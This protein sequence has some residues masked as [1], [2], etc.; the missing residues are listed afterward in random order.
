[1]AVIEKVVGDLDASVLHP[2]DASRLVTMFSKGQRLCTAGVTVCCRQ[3]DK[4]GVWKRSGER[5]AADWLSKT[6]GESYKT[7]CD[8]LETAKAVDQLSHTR[9]ALVSGK[10][11]G[12]QAKEIAS[13]ASSAPSFE[14]ELLNAAQSQGLS[15]LRQRCRQIKA[16]SSGDEKARHLAIHKARRLRWWTD[17]LGAFRLDGSFTPEAGATLLAALQPMRDAVFAQARRQGRKEGFDAYGADALVEMARHT[18]S[19]EHTPSFRGPRALIK[20]RVDAK[21]LQR[22]HAKAGETCEIAGVG[23]V[24]VATAQK[25]AADAFVAALQCDGADIAS[26]CH[27]GRSIPARLRTAL[28]ERDPECVVPRCHAKGYLEIDHIV[29][30][31]QNGP[32]CLSNLARLCSFH[33]DQKTY[34]GYRLVGKPA[35]WRWLHPDDPDP[36]ESGPPGGDPPEGDPP[37]T[38]KPT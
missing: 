18:A 3:V 33:H 9:Q 38:A 1:M 20:V 27:M 25:L 13:A 12:A 10:L 31:A 6:T 15:G 35:A 22:G 36:P 29:P 17:E 23:P 5:S 30:V 28:E 8:T 32:T 14:R 34:S 7:A 24:A 37:E 21:A 11:S 19:C 2:D 16:S 4:S 26:V